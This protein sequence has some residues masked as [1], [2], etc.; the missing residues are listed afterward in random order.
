MKLAQILFAGIV[1]STPVI[2]CPTAG[3]T[4]L[5]QQFTCTTRGVADAGY[6]VTVSAD[7]KK[8]VLA[9]MSFMGAKK[10]ADLYCVSKP[11]RHFPDALNN[12]LTCEDV[13]DVNG[14]IVNFWIGGI[15]GLHYAEVMMA[16]GKGAYEKVEFGHLNCRQ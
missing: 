15:A 11:V 13:R 14:P 12:Y 8:A 5:S 4:S 7:Y 6:A 3:A 9:E 16:N 10:I 1:I 2:V